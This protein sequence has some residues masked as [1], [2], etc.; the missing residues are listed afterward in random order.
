MRD[1]VL[2]VKLASLGDILQATALLPAFSNQPVDWLVYSD[3]AKALAGNPFI[4]HVIAIPRG[5][6]GVLWVPFKVK[7]GQY[8]QVIIAHRHR[9]LAVLFR[10]MGVPKRVGFVTPGCSNRWLTDAVSF[11][12]SKSRLQRFEALA[13]AAGATVSAMRPSRLIYKGKSRLPDIPGWHVPDPYVVICPFGACN[14][15]SEMP[16]RRWPYFP[17]LI[18]QLLLRYP[19]YHYVIDG[20]AAD[21]SKLRTPQWQALFAEGHVHDWA[22]RLSIDYLACV[23]SHASLMIGNDSFPLFL[24][25]S[26]ATPAVG[27][28]GPTSGHL[29]M[30]GFSD[31]MICQSSL[32]C[33]PCYD[34]LHVSTT[35]AYQCPFLGE[36]MHRISPENVVTAASCFLARST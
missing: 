22:G 8:C 10:W 11:D 20:L 28:F 23:L 15:D 21:C 14:R 32:A 16:T 36:C 34:P 31:V 12:L 33:S 30:D 19:R 24:A 18:R 27:I 6:L 26:Q 2:V 17:D 1:P 5:I 7:K 29:I 25:V 13:A 9:L 3:Q 35:L 4:R